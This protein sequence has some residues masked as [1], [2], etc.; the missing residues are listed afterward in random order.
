ML[1]QLE[2]CVHVNHLNDELGYYTCDCVG[3]SDGCL[4]NGDCLSEPNCPDMD[5]QAIQA[6]PTG[7]GEGEGETK[8]APVC[9]GD[10][11]TWDGGYGGCANYAVDASEHNYCGDDSD[12]GFLANEVCV[13]CGVC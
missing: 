6:T 13:Q 1:N 8:T 2:D 3:P 11:S 9:Q 7:E 4:V 5:G 10:A 12:Q